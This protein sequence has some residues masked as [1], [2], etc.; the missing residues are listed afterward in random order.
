MPS[1]EQEVKAFKASGERSLNELKRVLT[2]E[3]EVEEKTRDRLSEIA[4][5]LRD[6]FKAEASD[7]DMVVVKETVRVGEGEDA[8]EYTR[9]RGLTDEEKMDRRFERGEQTLS[10]ILMS[11][12]M[13]RNLKNWRDA[14]TWVDP[15]DDSLTA[16]LIR[17][18][19]G[20]NSKNIE[21]TTE[22]IEG[23]EKILREVK[24]YEKREKERDEHEKE[25][26]SESNSSE[27]ETESDEYESEHESETSNERILGSEGVLA[28]ILSDK[29]DEEEFEESATEKENKSEELSLFNKQNAIL[30]GIFDNT[31]KLVDSMN[32]LQILHEKIYG[33]LDED[34]DEDS[35]EGGIL[36]LFGLSKKGRIKRKGK[37]IIG[38]TAKAGSAIL[39]KG[40]GVLGKVGGAGASVLGSIFRGSGEIG[41]KAATS[42]IAAK[43]IEGMKNG[44][45][46]LLKGGSKV[47]GLV[48]GGAKGALR[49]LPIIGTALAGGL[50]AM[51]YAN[52]VEEID[53]KVADG[54]ITKEEGERLKAEAAG[55]AVGSTTGAG[56]G[57]TIGGAIGLLTPIPGGAMIGSAVGS[58]IGGA[59]GDWIGTEAAGTMVS[60]AGTKESKPKTETPKQQPVTPRVG[61]SAAPMV[62]YPDHVETDDSWIGTEAA[63]TLVPEPVTDSRD[64]GVRQRSDGAMLNGY[65][66]SIRQNESEMMREMKVNVVNNSVQ[67]ITNS[68]QTNHSPMYSR[69]IDPSYIRT[70]DERYGIA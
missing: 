35:K 50:G 59:A 18:M 21:K 70:I 53:R 67:N 13:M 36:D 47:G 23:R 29:D 57:A 66:E 41:E 48:L 7:D 42:S 19:L 45:S 54:E 28:S 68:G 16:K 9:F 14:R 60:K 12:E 4:E 44:G 2:E 1:V 37:V 31:V 51:D 33:K 40:A 52:A 65:A 26:R 5:A 17:H 56:I 20:D 58:M 6:Q 62:S 69:N 3:K 64:I 15:E 49:G 43:T 24:E 27:S 39:K 25:S 63:G 10:D 55:S 34:D 30:K 11:G 32:K 22:K 8:K 61:E 38:K 46:A